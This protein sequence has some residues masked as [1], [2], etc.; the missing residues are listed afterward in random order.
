M[1]VKLVVF[2][3]AGTT[4]DDYINGLPLVTVAMQESFAKHGIAVTPS[5]VDG[6]RGMDKKEAIFK[7]LQ[8]YYEQVEEVNNGKIDQIFGDFKVSLNRHLESVNKEIPGTTEIFQKLRDRGIKIGL[9]SGFPQDV[10]RKIV[11]NLNWS[12]L[13]DFVSSAEKEGSG[14]PNPSLIKSAMAAFEITDAKHVVK[15]GDTK[16]DVLEGRN[17]GCWTVAV[18]TGTQ[19]EGTLKEASPDFIVN[20]VIDLPS[21]ISEIEG[22]S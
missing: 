8:H 17:A 12:D 22:K 7:L 14:R 3:L 1:V 10:V 2:D 4:V 18:R 13:A 21:V 15:I 9:G 6:V 11:K 16:M 20:S 19:G 5:Q